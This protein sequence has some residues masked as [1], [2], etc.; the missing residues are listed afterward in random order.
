[1]R[2]R[3]AGS[4]PAH[5]VEV[6]VCRW[7][8]NLVVRLS[9]TQVPVKRDESSNLSHGVSVTINFRAVILKSGLRG[10]PATAIEFFWDA[11]VQIRLT[12]LLLQKVV[13]RTW[14][15]MR[16]FSLVRVRGVRIHHQRL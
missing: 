4:N 3:R 6:S 12:A 14:V 13:Q 11:S 1:M 16:A 10:R 8:D 15:P 7:M 5:G 2:N 9:G